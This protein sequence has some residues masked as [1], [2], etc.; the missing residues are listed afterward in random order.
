M[1]RPRLDGFWFGSEWRALVNPD[2]PPTARQLLKLNALGC[3]ELVPASDAQPITKAEAAYALN[4]AQQDD[5]AD[6]PPTKPT[7]GRWGGL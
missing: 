4:D 1:K 5:A 3:L 2:G 6:R 7:S